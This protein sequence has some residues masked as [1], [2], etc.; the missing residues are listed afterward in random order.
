MRLTKSKAKRVE[1][2]ES[3]FTL[4]EDGLYRLRLL[5]VD[6]RPGQAPPRGKGP[7]WSWE[8]KVVEEGQPGRK[9]WLNTSLSEDSE[10]KLKE[11]FQ[12][13][14]VPATTD[15]EELVGEEVIGQVGTRTI[16]KGARVGQDDNQI[17]QLF[18]LSSM[19]HGADAETEDDAED[20]DAEAEDLADDEDADEPEV[21]DD[22]ELEEPEEEKEE[23]EAPPVRRRTKDTAAQS[24]GKAKTASGAVRQGRSATSPAPA[25][26][27][28]GASRTTR[29]TSRRRD[30][31]DPMAADDE[32]LLDDQGQPIPFRYR[33]RPFRIPA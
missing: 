30:R 17:M 8:F 4:L 7:Y 29:S 26:S 25:S 23:E 1:A 32:P 21:V 10:W 2:A 33:A 31:G 16:E 27:K 13:F 24:G 12:A 9:L 18:P 15:T 20:E 19:Q 28:T 6:P 22:D 11:T 3:D 14:E 5:N